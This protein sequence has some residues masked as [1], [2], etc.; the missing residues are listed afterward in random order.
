MKKFSLTKQPTTPYGTISPA[1]QSYYDKIRDISVKVGNG[2]K[3]YVSFTD[4][5]D[6]RRQASIAYLTE[7]STREVQP[8]WYA[9]TP[10]WPEIHTIYVSWEG[11]HNKIRVWPGEIEILEE[12]EGP[13]VWKWEKPEPPAADAKDRT[14]RTIKKGDFI[15]FVLH[16]HVNYGTTIHFGTVTKVTRDGQVWAKN[17]KVDDKETVAEKRI[18]HNENIVVLTKD[19]LDILMVKKL[20]SG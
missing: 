16:H 5:A 10:T 12:Y 8:Y 17:I 4:C 1:L 19:L 2:E 20:A 6:A 18:K 7:F 14:G 3:V 9:K 13:S 11:R 15:T